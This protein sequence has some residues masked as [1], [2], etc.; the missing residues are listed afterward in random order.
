MEETFAPVIEA[1]IIKK[2]T[3]NSWL[4][5]CL[6]SFAANLFSWWI[7]ALIPQNWFF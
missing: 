6:L 1:L 4:T 2:F 3:D 5:A 7:G